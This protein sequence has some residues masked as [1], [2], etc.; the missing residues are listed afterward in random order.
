VS[1]IVNIEKK[2]SELKAVP[3]NVFPTLIELKEQKKTPLIYVG[4]KSGTKNISLLLR[5][6]IKADESKIFL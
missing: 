5:E 4:S 6:T 2:N 1:A 3:D